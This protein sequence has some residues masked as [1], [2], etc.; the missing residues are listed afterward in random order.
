MRIA[1]ASA[2][3]VYSH[4]VGAK[5][6]RRRDSRNGLTAK[7]QSSSCFYRNG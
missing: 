3:D 2:G 1:P 7:P 6:A 4:R 5:N